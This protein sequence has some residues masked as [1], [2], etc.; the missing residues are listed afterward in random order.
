MKI[1]SKTGS[2]IALYT[3]GDVDGCVL[4]VGVV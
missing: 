1:K 3:F 4:Y 2:K